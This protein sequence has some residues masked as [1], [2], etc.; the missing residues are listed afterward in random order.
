[1]SLLPKLNE[2]LSPKLTFFLV[3]D[4]RFCRSLTQTTR[5]TQDCSKRRAN[6]DKFVMSI[7]L[8][9]S[10]CNY[11]YRE[12]QSCRNCQLKFNLPAPLLTRFSNVLRR[13]R[14]FA[15][16]RIVACLQLGLF[17]GPNTV[18]QTK[19]RNSSATEKV[20]ELLDQALCLAST[21]CL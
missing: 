17:F 10:W 19:I 13:L 8:G 7:N 4:S 14:R 21:G 6:N 11:T 16:R 15:S 5:T 2:K 20:C 1:M 3:T 9:S 18:L 12:Q